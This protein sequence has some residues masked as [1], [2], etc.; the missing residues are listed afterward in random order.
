VVADGGS[1]RDARAREGVPAG[2]P[3]ES[4]LDLPETKRRGGSGDLIN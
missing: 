4:V 2:S 3:A 1:R